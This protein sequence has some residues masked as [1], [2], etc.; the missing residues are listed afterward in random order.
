MANH[1]GDFME[2]QRVQQG[3]RV[4]HQVERAR[5]GKVAVVTRV[6]TGGAAITALVGRNHVVTGVSQRQHHLA[7]AVGQLG[8]TM[9]QQQAAFGG[10][11]RTR[12]E[13]SHVHA[14]DALYGAGT[15]ALWELVHFEYT[16]VAPDRRTGPNHAPARIAQAF[17]QP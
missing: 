12:F 13:H 1:G 17:K 6:P 16:G 4:L 5:G 15:N 2:P 9:Q 7:P 11:F 14:V 10:L 8:E 3:E